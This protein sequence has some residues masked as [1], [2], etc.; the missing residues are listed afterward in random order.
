MNQTDNF[1]TEEAL[2]VQKLIILYT[3]EKMSL[4]ETPFDQKLR[5]YF[6]LF[7]FQQLSS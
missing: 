4:E 6:E 1:P 3:I 2:K 5:H 7:Q